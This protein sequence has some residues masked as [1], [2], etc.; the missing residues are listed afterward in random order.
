MSFRVFDQGREEGPLAE[1]LSAT[2]QRFFRVEL[3]VIPHPTSSEHALALVAH[4][5]PPEGPSSEPL[6]LRRRQA[7]PQ[8]HAD[9]EEA[10]RRGKAGGMATLARR[11][12]FVWDIPVSPDPR[13][14]LLLCAVLAAVVLGPI[15]PPDGATLLGVRSARERLGI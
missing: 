9:A 4:A 1:Q 14:S 10:E 3:E 13:G 5:H 12:P 6:E 15:L 7:T 8:D 11:C 2:A